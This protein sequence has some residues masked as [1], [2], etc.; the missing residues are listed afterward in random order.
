MYWYPAEGFPHCINTAQK[1]FRAILILRRSFFP[2]VLIQAAR[3]DFPA[4]LIQRGNLFPC[5]IITAGKSFPAVIISSR[6]TSA[7]YKY[8]AERLPRGI[9][10]ARKLILRSI[11][12]AGK[13]SPP[14]LI[15]HRS[16][17]IFLK[18]LSCYINTRRKSFPA[19]LIP[20]RSPSARY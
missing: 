20:R 13:S 9:N 2:A 8:C 3:K 14:V 16:F 6:S 7:R 5:S 10:T 15:L 4:V 17:L 11:N 12:T 18:K 1:D 19:V